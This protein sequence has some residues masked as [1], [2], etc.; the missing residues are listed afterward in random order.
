[1]NVPTDLVASK[2]APGND[3]LNGTCIPAAPLPVVAAAPLLAVTAAS[4][5]GAAVAVLS[6]A[7]MSASESADFNKF[8]SQDSSIFFAPPFRPLFTKSNIAGNNSGSSNAFKIPPP[9]RGRNM[10]VSNAT[11]PIPVNISFAFSFA[12]I[13]SRYFFDD[14]NALPFPANLPALLAFAVLTRFRK[15]FTCFTFSNF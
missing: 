13:A 3:P 9:T 7:S 12:L 10:P 14:P 8:P 1:M 4:E 2:A 15:T 6:C 5:A 11:P